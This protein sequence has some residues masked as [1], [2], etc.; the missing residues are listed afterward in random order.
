M[1]LLTRDGIDLFRII[2]NRDRCIPAYVHAICSRNQSMQLNVNTEQTSAV[3]TN[4]I[5]I[6]H[7]LERG[8]G[9]IIVPVMSRL[10]LEKLIPKEGR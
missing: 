1:S 9:N 2:L 5:S 4:D 6:R 7:R 8:R 10:K 3:F